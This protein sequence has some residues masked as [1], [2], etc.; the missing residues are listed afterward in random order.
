MQRLAQNEWLATATAVGTG[1]GTAAGMGMDVITIGVA[2]VG[3]TCAIVSTF[4]AMYFHH[5]NYKVNLQ[6]LCDEREE[7]RY[8]HK[9]KTTTGA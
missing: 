8:Q 1:T 6:R 7:R 9:N 4:A 2:I 5:K 3:A